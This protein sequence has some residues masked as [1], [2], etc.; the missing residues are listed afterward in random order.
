MKPGWRVRK[1]FVAK[2]AR[3]TQ[4]SNVELGFGD[5]NAERKKLDKRDS[6]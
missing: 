4:K 3:I 5:V 2:F 1:D 6:K